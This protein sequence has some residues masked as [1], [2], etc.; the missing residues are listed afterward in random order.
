MAFLWGL[1]FLSLIFLFSEP[2]RINSDGSDEVLMSKGVDGHSKIYGSAIDDSHQCD[3]SNLENKSFWREIFSACKIIF[4]NPAFLVSDFFH[5]LCTTLEY[6]V[7]NIFLQIVNNI[8]I[9]H[10]LLVRIH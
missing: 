2:E 6:R 5:T 8:S 1:Q 3:S 9:G 7:L 4:S 10:S